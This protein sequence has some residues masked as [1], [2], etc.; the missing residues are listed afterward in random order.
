[1]D[2]WEYNAWSEA[3][4]ERVAD[5]LS[6]QIQA[7]YYGAYWNGWTKGHK[8]TL[9]QVLKSLRTQKRKNNSK[10]IDVNKVAEELKQ[11]EE[12]AKNGWTKQG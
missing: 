6:L 12:L 3:W 5:D 8:K 9:Q 2:L 11:A 7:A 4:Q 1:M 10:P